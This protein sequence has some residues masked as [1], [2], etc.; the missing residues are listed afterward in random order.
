M[1]TGKDD[2]VPSRE[3]SRS[4][5]PLPRICMKLKMEGDNYWSLSPV[6]DEGI[7]LCVWGSRGS[8]MGRGF[9]D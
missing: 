4:A 2:D 7:Y 6:G 8:G 1:E 9:Y 5:E 3:A